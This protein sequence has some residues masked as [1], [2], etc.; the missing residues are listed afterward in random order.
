MCFR[1]WNPSI[2]P[3]TSHQSNLSMKTAD[4]IRK[5]F[6]N[7]PKHARRCFFKTSLCNVQIEVVSNKCIPCINFKLSNFMKNSSLLFRAAQSF[8]SQ[9]MNL[10]GFSV[11]VSFVWCI[12]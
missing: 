2:Q 12:I 6:R 5:L 3:K 1:T 7:R 11:S 8:S 4:Q 9:F 10:F